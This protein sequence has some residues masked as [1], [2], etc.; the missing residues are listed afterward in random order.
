MRPEGAKTG[1][2]HESYMMIM[3]IC[4]IYLKSKFI[5]IAIAETFRL[6]VVKSKLQMRIKIVAKT[7]I[8][9]LKYT[10]SN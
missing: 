3:K 2:S 10:F 8:Q 6:S 5:A 9:S 4:L 7:L 1:P